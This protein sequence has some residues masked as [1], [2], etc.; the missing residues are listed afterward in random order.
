MTLEKPH[1]VQLKHTEFGRRI[2]LVKE[3]SLILLK[4][5]QS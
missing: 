2:A 4:G 1:L 3:P 5:I